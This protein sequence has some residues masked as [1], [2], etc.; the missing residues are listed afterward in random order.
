M[1]QGEIDEEKMAGERIAEEDKIQE[2]VD[3]KGNR[4]RKV[5][6]GGGSHFRNWYDQIV[7]IK[8]EDNVE[9]EEM[10]SHGFQCYEEG[11]EKLYRIWVKET[12]TEGIE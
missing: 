10:D 9:V 1:S 8:G 6:F 5:Y 4:W 2:K 11:G 7:E 12:G 3:A